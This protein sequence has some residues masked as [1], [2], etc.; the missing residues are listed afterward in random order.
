MAIVYEWRVEECT[1]DEHEDADDLW[2]CDTYADAVEYQQSETPDGYKRC[3]CLNRRRYD[4]C[5]DIVEEDWAYV[6]DGKLPETFGHTSV[7]VPKR[8]R[9]EVEKFHA[10]T[11]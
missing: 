2:F 9:S 1:A 7:K 6:E 10:A 11:R 8:F 5:E 4:E 3:I